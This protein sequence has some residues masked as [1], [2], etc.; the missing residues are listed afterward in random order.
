MA[1]IFDKEKGIEVL[2]LMIRSRVFEQKIEELFTLHKMH[3][4]T[5]LA[6][7]QEAV[8]AG[9]ALGIE[10]K[11]WIVTTHRCHGHTLAKGSSLD[12]MI[13]EFFGDKRGLSKGL[14]GS[15]HLIDMEHHN[16]GSSAV[17]ASGV[18]IATGM[19]LQLKRMK[20]D[21]IVVAFF[22]DGASNRG[23]IHEA[24]NMASI[25]NL[26]VLFL[27]EHN[28]Y[29]MSSSADK[30]IS[31][32]SIALRGDS[33]SIKSES[34]DGNDV[35]LVYDRVKSITENIKK[36]GRPYLL[37][38][39]TYRFSGHS[40][41]DKFLYRTREEENVWKLKDPI[42]VFSDRLIS[43]GIIS[44]SEIEAIITSEKETIEKIANI[45]LNDHQ[46]LTLE[47]AMEFVYYK[48]EAT[49]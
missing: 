3:G 15:M 31:V 38:T 16:A 12:K 21:N 49:L 4:T 33:Y 25:W 39:L 40:K 11:D 29:G 32:P 45:Y 37:E 2:T 6:I 26:P 1:F 10:Q 14:G 17:V 24:M 35:E 30:M 28:M 48:E 27:C 43:R 20:S 7:G 44:G 34:I 22:G 19:A 46:E 8:H 47:E 23:V 42:D 18:A 41:N 5:H 36:E 9:V 13:A